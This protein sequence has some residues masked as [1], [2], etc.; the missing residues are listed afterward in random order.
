MLPTFFI[1]PFRSGRTNS[2]KITGKVNKKLIYVV[3]VLCKGTEFIYSV[4]D[5][6]QHRLW[7]RASRI[8]KTLSLSLSLVSKLFLSSLA[9]T[10]YLPS[11]LSTCLALLL[12]LSFSRFLLLPKPKATTP[13]C[14]A[15]VAGESCP[16]WR[17]PTAV[18]QSMK[19]K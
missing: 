11:C 16:P 19:I 10:V 14:P 5:F 3:Y 7:A 9:V 8:K 15:D 17:S 6:P 2:L 1:K 13:G 12:V 18:R 4:L